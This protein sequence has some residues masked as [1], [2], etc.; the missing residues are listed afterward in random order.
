[1]RCN[2]CWKQFCIRFIDKNIKFSRNYPISRLIERV[3]LTIFWKRCTNFFQPIRNMY[4]FQKILFYN[5][6]GARHLTQLSTTVLFR[7]LIWDYICSTSSRAVVIGSVK[8][9]LTYETRHHYRAKT[10]LFRCNCRLLQRR[11]KLIF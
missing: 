7:D 4:N 2:I 1:M 9:V 11:L 10:Y 3:F 8:C 5:L 6:P